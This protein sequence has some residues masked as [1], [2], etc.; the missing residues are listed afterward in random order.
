MHKCQQGNKK[1]LFYLNEMK[2]ID[3]KQKKEE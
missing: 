1:N 3:F 2:I